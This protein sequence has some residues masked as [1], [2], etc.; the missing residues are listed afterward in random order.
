MKGSKR[1]KKKKKRKEKKE[2]KRKKR[3]KERKFFR[4]LKNTQKFVERVFTFRP[5]KDCGDKIATTS[6]TTTTATTKT[7]T[8]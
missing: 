7:V 5:G 1:K 4:D 8:K 6:L 2:K 3:I